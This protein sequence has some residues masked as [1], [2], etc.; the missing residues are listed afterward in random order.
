MNDAMVGIVT[1]SYNLR[2]ING[3][4]GMSFE[5]GNEKAPSFLSQLKAL[6]NINGFGSYDEL[7]LGTHPRVPRDNCLEK[8]FTI[9]LNN[10][11]G[12]W[13]ITA[14]EISS[15]M[16]GIRTVWSTK[17]SILF[18]TGASSLRKFQ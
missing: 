8:G 17:P 12:I 5:K 10:K 2:G 11:K 18:D 1:N 3:I 13:S 4:M 9:P 7:I 14:K 16:N 15:T 6:E